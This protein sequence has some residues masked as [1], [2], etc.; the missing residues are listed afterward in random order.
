MEEKPNL[1]RRFRE[2]E[3]E[4]KEE[5]KR[6]KRR[7]RKKRVTNLAVSVQKNRIR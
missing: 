7:K 5:V 6:R 1:I 3:E 4:W 2:G